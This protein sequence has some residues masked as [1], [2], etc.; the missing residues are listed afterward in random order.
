MKPIY[1]MDYD[2]CKKIFITE[3][4]DEVLL[5][6]DQ[7]LQRDYVITMQ[8]A[9]NDSIIIKAN[10]EE[11]VWLTPNEYGVTLIKDPQN[12]HMGYKLN[13]ANLFITDGYRL[14]MNRK[15]IYMLQKDGYKHSINSLLLMNNDGSKIYTE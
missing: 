11:I 2:D 3:E 13:L 5:F 12:F 6:M 1:K 14:R 4:E 7:F 9:K 10:D 15:Q 8:R